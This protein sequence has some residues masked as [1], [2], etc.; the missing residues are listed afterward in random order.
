MAQ[1]AAIAV[2]GLGKVFRRG[3]GLS[4]AALAGLDLVVEE[5]AFVTLLG[6]TGCGKTTLLRILLG[7]EAPSGGS[8]RVAGRVPVEGQVPAGAVFQ[9]HSLLPWRRALANVMFP[10]EMR[11]VRRRAARRQALDLLRLVGLEEAAGAFPHELSGGMQQRVAIARAL[12]HNASILL[13]D[14][15]FGALDDRTRRLLQ[16]VLLDI[17]ESRQLTVLFVTHNIEEALTLGD[18][19]LVLGQGRILEDHAVPLARPRDPLSDAFAAELLA[20]R[21]VFAAAAEGAARGRD[22]SIEA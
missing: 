11:G 9:Q 12:A 3:D 19:I 7:L 18:R 2:Q 15:P 8:V 14:E 10:L 16:A 17:W 1:P 13:L 20:L 4:V 6:P 22:R 5:R 21:R